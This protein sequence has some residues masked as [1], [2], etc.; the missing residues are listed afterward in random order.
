[1]PVSSYVIDQEKEEEEEEEEVGAPES[2]TEFRK[3][4]FETQM[5]SQRKFT[6][7][8][9]CFSL[10]ASVINAVFFSVFSEIACPTVTGRRTSINESE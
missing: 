3:S 10:T 4:D 1:M 7:G 2:K 5:F 6:L 9:K 8:Q